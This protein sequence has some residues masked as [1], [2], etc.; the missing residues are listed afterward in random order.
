MGNTIVACS[1]AGYMPLVCIL[2]V[3]RV[4]A[5]PIWVIAYQ[6]CGFRIPRSQLTLW[7]L[8]RSSG[9][10]DDICDISYIFICQEDRWQPTVKSKIV[11]G[12][13]PSLCWESP[14][15]LNLWFRE[16]FVAAA[17]NYLFSHISLFGQKCICLI[18]KL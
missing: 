14:I 1:P 9:H 17:S 12:A 7:S 10:C 18:V 13:R 6:W 16:L 11:G 15:S 4:H 5:T 8:W 3:A 2:L